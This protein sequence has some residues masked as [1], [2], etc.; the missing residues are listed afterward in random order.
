MYTLKDLREMNSYEKTAS[1]DEEEMQKIAFEMGVEYAMEIEKEAGLSR[2]AKAGLAALGLA[3]AGAGV[4]YGANIGGVN[5]AITDWRMKR[6]IKKKFKKL[7]SLN[8]IAK[9]EWTDA[10]ESGE[11]VTPEQALKDGIG[12]VKGLFSE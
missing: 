5:D 12:K 6:A 3:G 4:A 7:E 11:V 8:R 1:F 2:G 10:V 9:K